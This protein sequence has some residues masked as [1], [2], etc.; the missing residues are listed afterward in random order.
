[1]FGSC[2]R[3]IATAKPVV[4]VFENVKGLTTID[5]GNALRRV[6]D[7]LWAV[8]GRAYRIHR[9]RGDGGMTPPLP[10]LPRTA[11]TA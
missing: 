2:V 3:Y 10:R 4:F 9:K 11:S 5:E 1:M 7:S 8:D 6:L